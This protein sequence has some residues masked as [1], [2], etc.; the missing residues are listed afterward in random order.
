[1]QTYNKVDDNISSSKKQ[2]YWHTA[3]GLQKVDGLSPSG[4]MKNLA[5][6]HI[7]GKK[8]YYEVAEEVNRYYVAKKP[9]E[10]N[11]DEREADIV[12]NAIYAILSDEAFSFD[13][14]T[15]KSYHKRL[16]EKLD[17]QVF[18][19]G[20]FRT[21]NITK[22][23]PILDGDTVQYQDFGL[24][25]DSLNYDFNEEKSVDYLKMA[26]AE[27]LRRLAEFTSRIWQ[28]HP[29]LEGNTRTTAVFIEKYLISLGYQVNNDLF[30][31][32]SRYFRDA[33]VRA[34]YANL[35]KNIA[36]TDQYLIKFFGNLLFS[37]N[38]PLSDDLH[39]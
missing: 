17:H 31:D 23:E 6:E 13:V 18:R 10:R 22:K 32:H 26:N 3:F 33:L 7:A 16:F 15:Y 2:E 9:G 29:F 34:N 25:E 30:R 20:E 36:K 19:P 11:H 8:S 35:P 37:A 12:S 39:I 38:H 24:L 27:K 28:V 4:Y 14:L 5:D 1:M 21:V